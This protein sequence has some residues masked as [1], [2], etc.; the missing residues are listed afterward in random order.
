MTLDDEKYKIMKVHNLPEEPHMI[1][2]LV[3][4]V[5]TPHTHSVLLEKW[6]KEDAKV[7]KELG[8]R[9]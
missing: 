9:Q 1:T 4:A 8:K 7:L 2:D 6:S 5:L 3:F